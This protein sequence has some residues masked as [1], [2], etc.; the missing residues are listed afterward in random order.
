MVVVVV[1]VFLTELTSNI[2]TTA[3]L[4]PVLSAMAPGLGIHPCLLIIP[5]AIAA[6]NL[7]STR[8]GYA[9][10][11]RVSFQD[12][13][14]YRRYTTKTFSIRQYWREPTLNFGDGLMF[15][16]RI[17]FDLIFG[18]FVNRE[19]TRFGMSEIQTTDGGTRPHRER[20]S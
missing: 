2:A 4:L 20:L 8:S 10:N 14:W 13:K 9:I 1:V 19:I 7:M 6:R 5:T 15:Q 11:C 18:N 3:T 16:F 12:N 17:M